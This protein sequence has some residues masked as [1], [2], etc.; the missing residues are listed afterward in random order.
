[1]AQRTSNGIGYIAGRWPLDSLKSTIVLIHG[2]GGSSVFWQAQVEALVERVNTVAIDLPG[3]GQSQGN[4]HD[5]IE[6]YALAV[7][8][9]IRAIKTPQPIPCGISLG[10]AVVQQLLLDY[11]D[12][13]RAA[14]IIG[15]GA[16]LKVAPDIFDAIEKDINSYVELMANFAASKST[17]PDRIKRFKDDT[18]RC[19]P[20]VLIKDFKACNRFDVMQRVGSIRSPVLVVT[21]EDDLVTPPKYGDFLE[22][23]LAQASR[24]HITEA[25]HIVPLE[26]PE[27]VN[28]AI[29][30][31]LDRTGL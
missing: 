1:M 29:L 22:T 26:K 17:D 8:D 28:R 13:F 11:P 16:K 23:S 6:E 21:A 31:F 27:A 7:I 5:R 18:A 14:I 4:G 2:A 19:N 30:E 10:G 12:L 3:H 25:G 9:F 20:E 15:S 24:V